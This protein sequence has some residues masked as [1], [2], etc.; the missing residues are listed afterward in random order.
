MKLILG[1]NIQISFLWCVLPSR[2]RP[3]GC[4]LKNNEARP[5]QTH[6]PHPTNTDEAQLGITLMKLADSADLPCIGN[7][8]MSSGPRCQRFCSSGESQAPGGLDRET[9][10]QP[11]PAI[12]N[13][14]VR[15]NP[16]TRKRPWPMIAIVTL[17]T[18]R[19]PSPLSCAAP[20]SR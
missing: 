7:L 3:G 17:L 6:T 13:M 5:A 20:A 19:A 11:H 14:S 1:Q 4:L 15:I 12:C 9:L 2:G 18:A 10:T 8:R 16:I